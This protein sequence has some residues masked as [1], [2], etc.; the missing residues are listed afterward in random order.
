MTAQQVQNL[1]QTTQPGA[2]VLLDSDIGRLTLK[3]TARAK[4]SPQVEIN[5]NDHTVTREPEVGS[6]DTLLLKSGV[7]DLI[8]DGGGDGKLLACSR[9]GIKTEGPGGARRVWI[10]RLSVDGGWDATQNNKPLP[11]KWL[12]HSYLTGGWIESDVSYVG[13]ADEH[14]WY[15]HNIQGNHFFSRVSAKWCG[16]T[17]LQIVNRMKEVNDPYPEGFGDVTLE[18]CSAED[19]CLEQG[20]GG[21]AYT[22]RGGMKESVVTMKR[23]TVRLGCNVDLHPTLRGRATGALMMDSGPESNPG[24]GDAAWPGGT[25]ELR[26]T[27][28]DFEIGTAYPGVGSAKRPCVKVG[29]VGLFTWTGGRIK[30][31]AGEIAL[32]IQVS[33]QH[34]LWSGT[35]EIEGMVRYRGAT[36]QTWDEFVESHPETKA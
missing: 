28:C 35:P 36:Y 12:S 34:F 2:L 3:K 30:V 7:R 25:K 1:W 22:F 33:C 27:D 5:L 23:V 4:G 10:R 9:A 31:P 26:C 16:R 19:V 8:V 29:A 17:A 20:G 32:E 11:N 15:G 6:S 14:A 21:S 24:A 13:C 18:D